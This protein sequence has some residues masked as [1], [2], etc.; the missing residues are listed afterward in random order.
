MSSNTQL[1]MPE[2]LKTS[3]RRITA[4]DMLRGIASLFVC[5]FH[6]TNGNQNYLSNGYWLKDLGD[7]GWVGVEI[8]FVIS[9]FIIPYSLYNTRYQ[10]KNFK[11]FLL[12]RIGRIEPP[13]F[14]SIV[15]ILALN[16]LSMLSPYF[17]GKPFSIDYF[18]LLLH[19][20][21]LIDF[22][23]ETWLNSV[24]WTLAIEFQ[25]YLLIG[26][27]FPFINHR[28]LGTFLIVISLLLLS[29]IL[30]KSSVTIFHHIPYFLLGISIFRRKIGMDRQK[31]T[32]IIE[33]ILLA[34]IYLQYG[35]VSVISAGFTWV[36]LVGF[37]RWENKW[38]LWL[39]RISYS[40]YLV[41]VPFGGRLINLSMNFFHTDL[42]RTFILLITLIIT[43]CFS[44]LF[45]KCV[46]LPAIKFSHSLF[47]DKK[48]IINAT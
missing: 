8:F 10:V 18:N 46:E 15:L 38:V 33:L 40:L 29:N 37:E 24:F 5:I 7:F 32:W 3:D 13:Y 30:I 20:A 43:L 34:V 22:F 27:L 39:G 11:K 35:F 21:Y 23:K 19:V 14:L 12:K 41:H 16:Y 31:P 36:I 47:K 45:Y 44:Y 9:G 25:F 48:K 28:K 26:L 2:K 4:V 1:A 42:S 17:K 6:F